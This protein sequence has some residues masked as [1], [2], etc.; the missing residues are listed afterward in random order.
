MQNL[1]NEIEILRLLKHESTLKLYRVYEDTDFVHLVTD[2]A[3]G[4]DLLTRLLKRKKFSE[5]DASGLMLNLLSAINYIHSYRYVH[6]DLK[7]D[8]IL[9]VDADDDTKIFVC[10]FGLAIEVT[11]AFLHNKVGTPGYMAPEVIHGPHYGTKIDVFS[12]GLILYM[13]LS[14]ISPF[15]G[16]NTDDILNKNIKG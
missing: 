15:P 16:C 3:T 8:N 11:G 9:M 10:D 14:G 1:I 13:L 6:R 7:L 5:L 12:C 2:L 4:E